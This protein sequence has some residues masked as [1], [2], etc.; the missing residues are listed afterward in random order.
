MA[1]EL[2]IC[3]SNLIQHQ[4]GP[5]LSELRSC[6]FN[7]KLERC[8]SLCVSCKQE[9]ICIFNEQW[10]QLIDPKQLLDKRR[11]EQAEQKGK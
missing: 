3:V 1:D 4:S 9:S 11:Q 6:G 10:D 5:I 8:L 7:I 2:R